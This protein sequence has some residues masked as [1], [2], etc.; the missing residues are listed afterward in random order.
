MKFMAVAAAAISLILAPGAQAAGNQPAAPDKVVNVYNWSNYIDP[1]VL[2]DFTR[3]TGIRVRNDA[4]YDSYDSNEVAFSRVIAGN[5]GYD[6]VVPTNEFLARMIDG[7]ALAK[8]DKTK[9]PNLVNLDPALTALMEKYDP[10]NQYGVIYLWGTTGIGLNRDKIRQRMA[11]P[12]VDSLA[13]IFDPAIVARFSDCGVAMLDAPSEIIPAVLRYLGEDP[14]DKD[15]RALARAEAQLLKIRRHIRK[16]HSSQYID[17][18][19]NGNICLALGWSGDVLQAKM[20]AEQAGKGVVVQYL[21]PRQGAQMWFDSMAIPKDAPNPANALAFINFIHRPEVIARITNKVR[22]PNANRAADA[23]VA[24]EVKADPD[25]YPTPMMQKN[26]Y[27]ITPNNQSEQRL[28][29]QVWS[30]FK[31]AN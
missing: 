29:M 23:F 12:P 17:D 11:N 14:D 2:A 27:T 5:S 8:L 19:A 10:G 7:G 21:M 30:R 6:I 28:F 16:F 15:A 9:L 1:A 31:S 13:M 26:L 20:R 25:I 3:E 22:Y 24:E 18:L 4:R